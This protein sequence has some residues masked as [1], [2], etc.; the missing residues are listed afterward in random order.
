MGPQRAPRQPK[1][2]PRVPQERPK[3]LMLGPRGGGR[4]LKLPS[5][6]IDDLHDGPREPPRPPRRPQESPKSA[7]GGPQE[8]PRGL[9]DGPKMASKAAKRAPREPQE[10]PKRAP[11]EPQE[12]PRGFQNVPK[13]ALRWPQEAYK[14][15]PE[16]TIAK[17]LILTP[18][19]VVFALFFLVV[20]PFVLPCSSREHRPT[21]PDNQCTSQR[22]LF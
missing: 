8:R 5:L 21:T 11:R 9:Q 2:R 6:L 18:V 22:W 17:V 12:G 13:R 14:T 16:R 3:R 10:R 7:P 19:V 1:E 20:V 15:L 4:K